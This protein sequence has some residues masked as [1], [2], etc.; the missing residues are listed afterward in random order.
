[1]R[2]RKANFPLQICGVVPAGN[3]LLL[4]YSAD[5]DRHVHLRLRSHLQVNSPKPQYLVLRITFKT[6]FFVSGLTKVA[7][8]NCKSIL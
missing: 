8:R 7:L 3:A 1:M 6:A 4:K 2:A 5:D